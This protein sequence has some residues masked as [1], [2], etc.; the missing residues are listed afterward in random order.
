MLMRSKWIRE[1]GFLNMYD[2][3]V[4]KLVHLLHN[5]PGQGLATQTAL[6]CDTQLNDVTRQTKTVPQSERKIVFVQEEKEET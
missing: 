5:M 3:H 2:M 1:C 6:I 4:I